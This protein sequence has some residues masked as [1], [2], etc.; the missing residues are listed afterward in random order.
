M[1]SCVVFPL[2]R[3]L[4]QL[5]LLYVF[6]SVPVVMVPPTGLVCEGLLRNESSYFLILLTKIVVPKNGMLQIPLLS[7]NGICNFYFWMIFNLSNKS[8]AIEN[9]LTEKR[10]MNYSFK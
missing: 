8:G 3:N 1:S 2:L 7:E 4:Q 9:R 10:I 6:V 5:I